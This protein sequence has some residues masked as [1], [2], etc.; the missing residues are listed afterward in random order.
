MGDLLSF[1]PVENVSVSSGSAHVQ[2]PVQRSTP[3]SSSS[4]VLSPDTAP[5]AAVSS[6]SAF[7]Q[8]I[9]QQLGHNLNPPHVRSLKKLWPER[10]QETSQLHDA[11]QRLR[12]AG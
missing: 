5:I 6:E 10:V 1:Q 7:L 2:Q 3:P 9:G 8:A 12:A 11:N 4:P